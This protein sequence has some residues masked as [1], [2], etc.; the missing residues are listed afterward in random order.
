ML[1]TAATAAPSP[2]CT[3][4]SN[5]LH[6]QLRF[7]QL[8]QRQPDGT[9]VLSQFIG[10]QALF[11]LSPALQLSWNPKPLVVASGSVSVISTERAVMTSQL[12]QKM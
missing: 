3:A 10:C 8:M 12:L 5:F 1:E 7:V 6:E 11:W 4:I 2:S 9:F